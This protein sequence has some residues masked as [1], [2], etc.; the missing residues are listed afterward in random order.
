LLHRV[1]GPAV[2]FSEGGQVWYRK[3][4]LHR[5]GGPAVSWI[6]GVVEYWLN[7]KM[8]SE[9]AAKGKKRKG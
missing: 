9:R 4:K 7:D 6:G 5:V 8:V 2:E 1:G 3:G